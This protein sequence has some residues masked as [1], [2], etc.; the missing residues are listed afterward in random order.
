MPSHP[1]SRTAHRVAAVTETPGL[2]IVFGVARVR[3]VN[4]ITSDAMR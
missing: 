2:F 1:P 4:G 3:Q